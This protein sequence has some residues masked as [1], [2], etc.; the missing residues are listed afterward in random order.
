MKFKKIRKTT[1]FV[2]IFSLFSIVISCKKK[3][4]ITYPTSTNYGENIFNIPDGK[5]ISGES[6]SFEAN[7]TKNAN[8]TVEITNLSEKVTDPL[9]QKPTWLFDFVKGWKPDNYVNETQKFETLQVGNNDFKIVFV[10]T[11]GS[12]KIK[13]FEN[14]S[15]EPLIIK[16]FTW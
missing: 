9:K 5:L 11:N 14:A 6:Y 2:V 7:L 13:V 8:L 3:G 1:H 12:C 16:N 4:E 15:I 10:G